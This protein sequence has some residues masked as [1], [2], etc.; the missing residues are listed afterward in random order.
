MT[1]EKSDTQAPAPS[2]STAPTTEPAAVQPSGAEPSAAKSVGLEYWTRQ[3]RNPRITEEQ[4][5][6]FASAMEKA[7]AFGARLQHAFRLRDAIT[8]LVE[9]KPPPQTYALELSQTD[10]VLQMLDEA[11]DAAKA[12]VDACA[13][14]L[15]QLAALTDAREKFDGFLRGH[16]V[17]EA[18]R[19][20]FTE[21]QLVAIAIARI[22]KM[23]NLKLEP[24]EVAVFFDQLDFF[25]DETPEAADWDD[26]LWAARG[27]LDEN[28]KT[29]AEKT[30]GTFL[31]KLEAAAEKADAKK[32]QGE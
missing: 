3:D 22:E 32:K 15:G 12:F 23:T 31:A 30:R 11:N 21:R 10:A 6:T 13:P 16:R 5:V 2:N 17:F 19:K 26:K 8:K 27:R 9:V 18:N 14:L 24:K 28:G 1:T 4:K 29:R 25:G 20:S 7:I